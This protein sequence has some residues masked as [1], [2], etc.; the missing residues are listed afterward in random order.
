MSWRNTIEIH[1]ACNELPAMSEAELRVLGK[2]IKANGL[3]VPIVVLEPE[4]IVTPG[5]TQPKLLD[6]RQRLDA[7]ELVGL[8][9]R[10]ECRRFKR[11]FVFR[12]FDAAGHE[13]TLQRQEAFSVEDPAGFVL[14]LNAHRRHLD[15]GQ[16]RAAIA[17]LLKAA[18]QQ[19]DRTIA[20]TVKASPTT[21]GTVRAELEEAGGVSKLDTRIDTK[22]RKQPATKRKQPKP[23]DVKKERRDR[24]VHKLQNR[25]GFPSPEECDR[26][27]DQEMAE[28]FSSGKIIDRLREELRAAEI[29]IVGL[30][31][32]VEDLKAQNAELRR[33]LE[34]AAPR[35]AGRHVSPKELGSNGAGQPADEDRWIDGHK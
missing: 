30:E 17:A 21:V 26:M 2:D 28:A 20:E 14:S 18:P 9:P 23:R 22:G 25:D 12:L 6:G 4:G 24:E 1:P 8:Q 11:I 13:Y 33:Q 32:E 5:Q 34:A 31:A 29:K 15:A 7:M 27:N 35:P 3:R 10:F 16:K 19:S